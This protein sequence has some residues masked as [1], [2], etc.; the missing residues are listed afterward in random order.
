MVLIQCQSI[1]W[2]ISPMAKKGKAADEAL[3]EEYYMLRSLGRIGYDPDMAL[4]ELMAGTRNSQIHGPANYVIGQNGGD[5]MT[6]I[7]DSEAHLVA[8]FDGHHFFDLNQEWVAFA[9]NGHVFFQRATTRGLDRS[10]TALSW[11]QMASR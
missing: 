5:S 11:T 10:I 4:T 2:R 6:P 1:I 3:F 9:A 7:L 8:W